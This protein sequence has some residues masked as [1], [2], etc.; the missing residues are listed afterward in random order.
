MDFIS[1]I[2]PDETQPKMKIDINA[3]YTTILVS[4]VVEC[5]FLCEA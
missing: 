4:S 2:V 1:N 3:S 5:M